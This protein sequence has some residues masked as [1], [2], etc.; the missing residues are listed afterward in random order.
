MCQAEYRHLLEEMKGKVSQVKARQVKC[1]EERWC[2]ILRVKRQ[3][4][5]AS[6]VLPTRMTLL[7]SAEHP[8]SAVL[9]TLSTLRDRQQAPKFALGEH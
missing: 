8:D 2:H 7:G 1:E 9:T 4:C 3:E 5:L 6:M